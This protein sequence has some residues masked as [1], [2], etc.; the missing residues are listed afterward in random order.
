MP[1]YQFNS[2]TPPR[3]FRPVDSMMFVFGEEL[4]TPRGAP[5]GPVLPPGV[6]R[7]ATMEQIFGEIQAKPAYWDYTPEGWLTLDL[8]AET[9]SDF[10]VSESVPGELLFDGHELAPGR[11]S[12]TLGMVFSL[13]GLTFAAGG[14]FPGF[15]T[16]IRAQGDNSRVYNQFWLDNDGNVEGGSLVKIDYDPEP[17]FTLG[18]SGVLPATYVNSW[19]LAETRIEIGNLSGPNAIATSA[20][21]RLG[22]AGG[23][24]ELYP[25]DTDPVNIQMFDDVTDW[26]KAADLWEHLADSTFYIWAKGEAGRCPGVVIAGMYVK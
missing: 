6:L 18:L 19:L 17:D 26:G 1:K 4:T 16:G 2:T 20:V 15:G 12:L 8:D 21:S 5:D 11:T 10:R 3:T 22:A 9:A 23:P 25:D 24:V 14:G 13:D 7:F